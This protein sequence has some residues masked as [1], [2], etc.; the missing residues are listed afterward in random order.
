MSPTP[1]TSVLRFQF[2]HFEAQGGSVL[3]ES[4]ATDINGDVWKLMI[5]VNSLS[6]QN[7]CSSNNNG[8]HHL[9]SMNF[10]LM[11]EI[12]SSVNMDD[13]DIKFSF[14]VRDAKGGVAFEEAFVPSGSPDDSLSVGSSNLLRLFTLEG[15]GVVDNGS[16]VLVNGTLVI[17]VVIQALPKPTTTAATH[18]LS[19]PFQR[20]M[21]NLFYSG[22]NADVTFEFGHFRQSN[23]R[24]HKLILETNAPILA[25]LFACDDIGT[26]TSAKVHIRDT[27]VEAFRFVLKYIYGG[28]P[29]NE[30]DMLKYGKEIIDAANKYGVTGL[31]LEAERA[32]VESRV[33]D[34]SNC[35]DF[36][37]FAHDNSCL[38]LKEYAI[39]YLVSR[40]RDVRNISD[41]AERLK[42]SPDLMF[43]I[44]CSI[45]KISPEIKSTSPVGSKSKWKGLMSWKRS[46]GGEKKKSSKVVPMQ[47]PS[48]ERQ[49]K[50][51]KNHIEIAGMELLGTDTVRRDA[52]KVLHQ[53][54]ARRT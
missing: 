42:D 28:S 44:L 49:K 43:E 36:I 32:L 4:S 2:P 34:V 13:D 25:S 6:P 26:S 3:A 5:K 48:Q 15:T 23:L 31:K 21:L 29:P 18:A 17:D 47:P 14:I 30:H 7:A 54:E 11:R 50:V 52:I 16:T 45:M 40:A 22:E 9:I 1:Q 38:L 27:S 33:V 8:N 12:T 39:S 53:C 46:N 20:N 35:I 19:N 51:D 10:V 24:A 41:Y 37:S